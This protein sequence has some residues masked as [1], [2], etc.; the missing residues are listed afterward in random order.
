[1]INFSGFSRRVG[2]AHELD[3]ILL[4]FYGIVFFGAME[5]EGRKDL[6]FASIGFGRGKATNE[7][8]QKYDGPFLFIM[9]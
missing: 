3:P 2:G 1:M 4:I 5:K 7:V 6:L 9:P 8:T